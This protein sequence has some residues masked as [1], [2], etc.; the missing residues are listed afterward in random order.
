MA[1][2]MNR[3][4]LLRAG[5]AAILGGFA[6]SLGGH[7]KSEAALR[8]PLRAYVP[9]VS[10]GKAEYLADFKQQH[11]VE[12]E[13]TCWV[14]N[15]TTLTRMAAGGGKLF[16][17]VDINSQFTLALIRQN[18]VQPLDLEQIP[19]AKYLFPM[20]RKPAHSTVDGKMY[21]LPFTAGY[22]SVLYNAEKIDHVDSYGALFDERHRGQISLRDDPQTSIAMTA[23]Y[24][25][26]T[27]PFDL[28]S[29]D[30]KKIGDF[31]I[32]K[33]P[34]F[35]RLWT[36]YGEVISMMKSGEVWLVGSAWLP[37]HRQLVRDGAK[38]KFARPKEKAL[39]WTHDL[40]IPRGPETR[41]MLPTVY[42]YMDWSL[43][44]FMAGHLSRDLA[45]ISP[46]KRALE[47][48]TS[49]EAK[50]SGYHEL[51]SLWANMLPMISYPE[52][53]QEWNDTWSRFKAA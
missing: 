37:M 16:D 47:L 18:L 26:H 44:K 8:G 30:L 6:A 22:D 12:V 34:L 20:F 27:K 28:T 31:L 53:L 10:V 29:A 15:T 40:L 5:S 42:A 13:V 1:T 7:A 32:S 19:N 24:L 11:K 51:D 35:R 14:S 3:R 41:D 21:S 23:L 36:G 9:C 50:A 45:Y 33:K 39:F 43:S 38:V 2:T 46:S 17:V 52:N 48:L 4:D 25:G 49:E